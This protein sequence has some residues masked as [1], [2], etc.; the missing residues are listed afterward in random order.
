MTKYL[1]LAL[2]VM[3]LP[4]NA[5]HALITSEQTNPD[6]TR[7]LIVI[8][9]DWAT[10]VVVQP[11]KNGYLRISEE[12]VWGH[13][14]H[15]EPRVPTGSLII[16]GAGAVTVRNLQLPGDLLL[17]DATFA[18]VS[19]CMLP[20]DRSQID[21][22]DAFFAT[23]ED[24]LAHS[25]RVE[26]ENPRIYDAQ[27]NTLSVYCQQTNSP[28]SFSSP[29]GDTHIYDIT[30]GNRLFLSCGNERNNVYID[31]VV[32]VNAARPPELSL[33]TNG[34]VDFVDIDHVEASVVLVHGGT[35]TD[36]LYIGNNN[37]IDDWRKY[38]FEYVK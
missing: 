6:G 31:G 34:G 7:N 24:C 18:R 23:V 3:T 20:A 35:S 21:V 2:A 37:Q 12:L 17:H 32:P 33:F 4:L 36:T 9:N 14:T 19:N 13:F 8:A 38:S 27:M 5:A 30:L 11:S 28:A 26:S 15:R 25:I 22:D 29:I 16:Y 1:L 10:D